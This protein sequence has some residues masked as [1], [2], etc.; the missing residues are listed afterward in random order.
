MFDLDVQLLVIRHKAGKNL[1]AK[2]KKILHALRL[3]EVPQPPATFGCIARQRFAP[4]L[5]PTRKTPHSKPSP[6]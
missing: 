2:S 3:Y 1:D 4:I 6:Y 5:H